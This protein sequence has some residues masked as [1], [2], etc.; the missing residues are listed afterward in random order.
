MKVTMMLYVV[1]HYKCW[2]GWRWCWWQYLLHASAVRVGWWRLRQSWRPDLEHYSY[3]ECKQILCHFPKCQL[4]R[5]NIFHVCFQKTDQ[6][7]KCVKKFSPEAR[8]PFF[9]WL[10]AK[11]IRDGKHNNTYWFTYLNLGIRIH[12]KIA[13]WHGWQLAISNWTKSVLCL[14]RRF[15]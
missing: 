1:W 14:F 13:D 2:L 12:N 9:D 5:T 3:S 6:T 4:L 10:T 7:C 8:K 15:L 11:C